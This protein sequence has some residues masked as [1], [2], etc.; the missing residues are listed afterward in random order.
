VHRLR[1]LTHL[2]PIIPF[3]GD[4]RL[5]LERLYGT[6]LDE[7]D[8][9][10][11]DENG[12]ENGNENKNDNNNDVRVRNENG[13]E[14]VRHADENGHAEDENKN[15]NNDV[16]VRLTLFCRLY[17]IFIGASLTGLVLGL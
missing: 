16:R 11:V 9:D 3:Q 4:P 14:H 15:N 13:N 6:D 2:L 17:L 7:S 8:N 10:N 5:A 1:V 12:N